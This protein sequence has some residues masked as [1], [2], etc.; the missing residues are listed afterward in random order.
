MINEQ[1]GVL[2]LAP[3]YTKTA[4]IVQD[5]W[6]KRKYELLEKVRMSK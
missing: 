6:E 1:E 4:D 3:E 2:L 5:D